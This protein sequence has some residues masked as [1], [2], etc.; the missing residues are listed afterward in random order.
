ML[1]F[2]EFRKKIVIGEH[3]GLSRLKLQLVYINYLQAL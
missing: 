1:I 3:D 2:K